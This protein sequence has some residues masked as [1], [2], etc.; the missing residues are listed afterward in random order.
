MSSSSI[1]PVKEKWQINSK[2][3]PELPD[4]Y[5]NNDVNPIISQQQE[6]SRS[7]NH[8]E[9]QKSSS[10][11]LGNNFLQNKI[12]RSP[13]E[14]TICKSASTGKIQEIKR[15]P[16][17]FIGNLGSLSKGSYNILK[18]NFLNF[19]FLSS[20]PGDIREKSSIRESLFV[21]IQKDEK[22]QHKLISVFIHSQEHNCQCFR[23]PENFSVNEV[24]LEAM[25]QLELAEYVET[26]HL[27]LIEKIDGEIDQK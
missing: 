13:T 5:Y 25:S 24:R 20:E 8:L 12:E 27:Y 17:C 11:N 9:K 7:Q 1:H 23:V 16:N 14:T 6:S 26:Y 19:T 4:K 22:E 3:L 2:E 18:I 10:K 21:D 15:D